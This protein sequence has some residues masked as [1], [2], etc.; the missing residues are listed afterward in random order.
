MNNDNMRHES[1]CLLDLLAAVLVHIGN[2]MRGLQDAYSFDIDVFRA[3]DFL[4]L[5][6]RPL[7]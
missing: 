5:R 1:H 2:Q 4:M 7:T 6:S 3:A